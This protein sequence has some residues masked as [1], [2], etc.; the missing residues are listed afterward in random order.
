MEKPKLDL[1]IGATSTDSKVS[2]DGKDISSCV[3]RVLIDCSPDRP[4][5]I[6]IEISPFTAVVRVAEGLETVEA[7]LG[8]KPENAS[9]RVFEIL[10]IT[11]TKV[12]KKLEE[13]SEK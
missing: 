9:D 12:R 2:V 6:L 11:S 3:R 5:R 10:D 4:T 13:L 1:V 8:P 7:Y